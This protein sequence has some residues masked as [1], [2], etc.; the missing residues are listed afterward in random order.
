MNDIFLK[1]SQKLN[2]FGLSED[3]V[4][5]AIKSACDFFSI[6]MPRLIQDMTNADN[7]Q[8]MFVNW[9]KNSYHDDVLCFD[10]RQLICMNVDSKESFSLVMTHECAHR[11]FQATNF[12]GVAG[13]IW[14]SELVADFFMGVR[15][16]LANMDESRIAAGLLITGG[17]QTH[18]EGRL[19]VLFIRHG[20][21]IAQVMKMNGA[22]LTIKNFMNE[23]IKFRN[24]NLAMIQRCQ[25]RYFD[26]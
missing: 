23:F 16:G 3:D 22:S 8:T 11:V 5:D 26:F 19:R 18:P 2:R 7:G 13:G 14:E 1:L 15:A 12:P 4:R 20:K 9:D 10:M 24:Q 21:Y 6:P 17:C 25:R